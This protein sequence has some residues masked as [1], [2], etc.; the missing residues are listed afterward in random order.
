MLVYQRVKQMIN[1]ESLIININ[2]W[3]LIMTMANINNGSS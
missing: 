1:R 2:I 3:Q